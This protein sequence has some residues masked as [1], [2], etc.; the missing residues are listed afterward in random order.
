MLMISI[1]SCW[2]A[3]PTRYNIESSRKLVRASLHGSTQLAEKLIDKKNANINHSSHRHGHTPL[4]AAV[5]RFQ[6]ATTKKLIDKGANIAAYN[7]N[8]H[9]ALQLAAA[10]SNIHMTKMLISE[11]RKQ[12]ETQY[13]EHIWNNHTTLNNNT[14]NTST[15]TLTA[16]QNGLIDGANN[17]KIN[18]ERTQKRLLF[19]AFVTSALYENNLKKVSQLDPEIVSTLREAL[20]Q[21]PYSRLQSSL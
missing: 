7:A 12:L 9:N 5:S 19:H 11:Y 3:E 16:V 18:R 20:A 13:P 15:N 14:P 4:T 2:S 1:N 17:L 6:V 21:S 10:C 8:G